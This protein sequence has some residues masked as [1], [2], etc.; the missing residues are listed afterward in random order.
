MDGMSY[1]PDPYEVLGVSRDAGV[2]QIKA[3]FRHA[4][5]KCH[6][7][8]QAGDADK[9]ERKFRELI[10]A[11]RFVLR[12]AGQGAPPLRPAG[13]R[14][15]YTPQDLARE[16]FAHVRR[17]VAGPQPRPEE[18]R[19]VRRANSLKSTAVYPTR[20]ETRTFFAL[21][22]ISTAIGI[23]VGG[24]VA[25]YRAANGVWDTTDLVISVLYAELIY[26][27]LALAAVAAVILTRRLVRYTLQLTGHRWRILP[28]LPGKEKLPRDPP[29]EELPPEAD[30][31]A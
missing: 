31:G 27:A 7:D 1:A 3:A 6:P 17:R 26:A 21:W 30:G 15:T 12:R 18:Y 14:Q 16:G 10:A 13:S 20:N 9:A 19:T 8:S 5:L 4:A 25:G 22:V 11:Y 23:A 24:A 29:D 2:A 28:W